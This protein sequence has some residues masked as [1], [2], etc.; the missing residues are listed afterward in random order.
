MQAGDCAVSLVI[1]EQVHGDGVHLQ[2]EDGGAGPAAQDRRGGC[3]D[4]FHPSQV[5][6]IHTRLL[7]RALKDVGAGLS[8][9]S[10]ADAKAAG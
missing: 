3:A 9:P 6:L 2:P 10:T 8:P 5:L 7:S 4:R 1:A